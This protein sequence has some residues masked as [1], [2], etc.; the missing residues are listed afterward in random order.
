MARNLAHRVWARVFR[1]VPSILLAEPFEC[2]WAVY[3][4]LAAFLVSWGVFKH[5]GAPAAAALP[6]YW[7]GDSG[8]YAW[9]AT[10]FS[11]GLLIGLGLFL[12]GRSP[13][14]SRPRVVEG[15][16]LGIFTTLMAQEGV[17]A[18]IHLPHSGGLFVYNLV[19]TLILAFFSLSALVRIVAIS[20]P[21]GLMAVSRVARIRLIRDQLR[22][23]SE[24]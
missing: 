18:A 7:G 17:L 8:V 4:M 9:S 20:S 15:S 3:G 6:R 11:A 22:K 12:A 10:L 1:F 13:L 23:G 2:F 14:S 24:L 19:S 21:S 5:Q 16:G